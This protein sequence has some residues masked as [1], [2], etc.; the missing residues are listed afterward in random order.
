M[1]DVWTTNIFKLLRE[2]ESIKEYSIS[3]DD[4]KLLSFSESGSMTVWNML[5]GTKDFEISLGS[6]LFLSAA[7]SHDTRSIWVSCN[8]GWMKE[9]RDGAYHSKFNMEGGFNKRNS[10]LNLVQPSKTLN[11]LLGR[12]DVGKLSV[13]KLPNSSTTKFEN[14]SYELHSLPISQFCFS[15]DDN[16]V[17]SV[18]N[19]GCL[20]T[21]K[22]VDKDLKR[23]DKEWSHNEEALVAFSDL[24]ENTWVMNEL[25][26]KVDELKQELNN[27]LKIKDSLH[28]EKL[29]EVEDKFQAEILL[30]N[31]T[32]SKRKAE[33]LES[34]NHRKSEFE[35]VKEKNKLDIQEVIDT[36]AKKITAE[37]S[38]H[39]DLIWKLENAKAQRELILKDIDKTHEADVEKIKKYFVDQL[40][41]KAEEKDFISSEFDRQATEYKTKSELSEE[42]V[43]QE[44]LEIEYSYE[45][46]LKEERKLSESLMKENVK[47]RT[48]FDNL[49]AQ[50]EARKREIH[51]ST[52]EEKR[53]K[54]IIKTFENEI[55]SLRKE[56]IYFESRNKSV[57][58]H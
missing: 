5:A 34:E 25:K 29:R 26:Q 17:F 44:I 49:S 52:L 30:L 16:Y 21:Y 50:I 56:V 24:Q 54:D 38:K 39:E 8:D 10:I 58:T 55:E 47:M 51:Q 4:R 33:L 36:F 15:A 27:Q 43:E 3:S 57:M 45:L 42:Q 48:H 28:S 9:Y 40:E 7:F 1:I 32:I 14:Q 23:V 41:K 37:N 53:T 22:V 12:N 6:E 11:S 19:D 2:G 13:I 46:K 18:G 31:E 20:V 35:T